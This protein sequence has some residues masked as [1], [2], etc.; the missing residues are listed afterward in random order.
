MFDFPP[1]TLCDTQYTLG[2]Y[3]LDY[4]FGVGNRNCH[5]VAVY[6]GPNESAR[7]ELINLRARGTVEMQGDAVS[8]L[9]CLVTPPQ[10]PKNRLVSLPYQAE[11]MYED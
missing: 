9:S 4:V 7:A 1:E 5:A 11:V 8:F 6:F 3:T 10:H 2:C